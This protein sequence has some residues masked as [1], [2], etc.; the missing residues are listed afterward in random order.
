MSD[1]DAFGKLT[2]DEQ[3]KAL[4]L[5]GRAEAGALGIKYHEKR[6]QSF[7]ADDCRKQLDEGLDGWNDMM[8][9]GRQRG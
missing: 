2:E 4:W 6:G 7:Q 3:S 1:A 5:A 9:R 8:K